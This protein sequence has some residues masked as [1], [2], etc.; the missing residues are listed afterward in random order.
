MMFRVIE[1]LKNTF[2]NINQ[3]S[4]IIYNIEF[5]Q[6]KRILEQNILFKTEMGVTD[7]KYMDHDII[8]SLTT[9]GKRLYD[10]ALTIESIMEQTMKANRIVLWLQDDLKNTTL[11]GSLELLKKRGLEIA[12][13]K[14]IRSYTKLVPSLHK[15]PNDA[16][17]T[18]DDDLLY[19][20]DV[21]EHLIVAYQ[22]NPQYIYCHRA[23]QIKVDLSGKLMP[24]SD[25]GWEQYFELPSN[26]CFPTGSGGV[27]YP[28]HSLDVEVF[29]EKIFMDICPFA[30]DVWFKAMAIK[31]GTLA[32]S[33]YSHN[34]NGCDY[35]IN[36]SVQDIGL[37]KINVDQ[38]RNDLQITAV[39][40]KYNLYQQFR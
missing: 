23:H 9:F 35:L 19:E 13:Y 3:S 20:Y 38:N 6:R 16:I 29:S 37:C 8:V 40:N 25:W 39:F 28:P 15:Y 1:K 21:L 36:E 34:K 10:V 12:F 5:Q 17:I 33:V 30:D 14:D 2:F 7:K 24:Y 11:P 4:R 32:V 22:H 26:L 27:L 31:K 18:V